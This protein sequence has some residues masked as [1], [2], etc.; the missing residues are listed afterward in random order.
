MESPGAVI[1]ARLR[2][3]GM[4]DLPVERA[5]FGTTGPEDLAA[6]V[7][8]WC[9]VYLGAPIERYEF[10][11]S[12][13]GSVHGVILADGRAVVVKGHRAAVTGEYLVAV[14]NL[15]AELAA[16]GYPAPAPLAGPVAVGDGHVTAEVMLERSPGVD[17]HDSD[18]RVALAGGLAQFIDLSRP[19]REFL[20]RVA[21]PM[22]V[23]D[24]ALYP[25]PHSLRF[26][27]GSTAA[28]AEWIDDLRSR[29]TERLPSS[30]E[31]RGVVVHGDWRI[32][33][34]S[35]RRRRLVG[36]FDWDSVH[37]AAETTAVASAATTFSV[38]WNQSG[39]PRFPSAGEMGAFV[40]DYEAARGDEFTP[41][42]RDILA[43]TVVASLAYGA[44]CEHAD[45][46]QPP[47]DDDCQRELLA[48]L[49]KALL[50]KGLAALRR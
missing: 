3:W 30:T 42:E 29:A 32:E 24:G 14:R 35:V 27:F 47:S 13:S 11:D 50:D 6:A 5:V 19:H 36:V 49:G 4:L 25:I 12:S 31:L 15:Q 44:R 2:E 17:G 37:V 33:N 43:A 34:L 10:F 7:D 9:R 21:H 38:D 28:G 46:G 16:S 45:A 26:D 18:V 1:A 20:G 40:S 41:D 23:P 22:R 39:G 8:R 48:T